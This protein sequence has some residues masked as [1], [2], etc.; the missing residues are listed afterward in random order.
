MHGIAIKAGTI[1]EIEKKLF[2]QPIS[3]LIGK[4]SYDQRL[5]RV[6][7]LVERCH[8]DSDLSLEKAAKFSGVS[9]NHL[10]YLLRQTTAFTFHQLLTR[11]RL[12]QAMY[13]MKSKNYSL[14]EIALQSGF[15]SLSAFERNF[16]T[17]IGATPLH[18]R[19]TGGIAENFGIFDET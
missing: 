18:F 15:G 12:L 5:E 17:V 1:Q 11:Y 19:R 13:M 8:I 9:K 7:Q 14:L 3:D 2:S 10:N 4:L 16:S 6:W